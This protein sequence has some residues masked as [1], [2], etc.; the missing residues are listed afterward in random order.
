[1]E[2]RQKTK[3]TK[4]N[5]IGPRSL[6]VLLEIVTGS[7]S[8]LHRQSYSGKIF[9]TL[10]NQYEPKVPSWD[11]YLTKLEVSWFAQDC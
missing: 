9:S 11:I 8:D 1:M 4:L 7:Q 5:L 2:K 10:L 3:R 6:N